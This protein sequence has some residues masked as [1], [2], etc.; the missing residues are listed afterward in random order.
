[1]VSI[2]RRRFLTISA[3]ALLAGKPA[4]AEPLR[5]WRGVALGAEV[6]IVLAHPEG[7][8]ISARAFAEIERLERIFSLYREESELSLLNRDGELAQPSFDML[9]CLGLC[10]AIHN[11][12][13]G[14]FDPTV[15]PLWRYYAEVYG[16]GGEPDPTMLMQRRGLVDLKSVRFDSAGIR[17]LKLG[18]AMTLNGIAQGFIA[19]KV[20]A[21]LRAEGLTDL[22]VNTGEIQALG[23]S[24]NDG[25]NGWPVT[26]KA[27]DDFLPEAIRLSD[28]A[29]AS[30]APLGTTIDGSGRVSHIISPRTG[31]PT[32]AIWRL[33]SISS[34][35]AAIADALSTAGCL[36]KK[37]SLRAAI[38]AFPGAKLELLA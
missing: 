6:M 9:E 32:E 22:L 3:A 7:D 2:D 24:P 29:L 13:D 26:L 10:N 20:A 23:N 35:S 21:L 4:F 27:G 17:Y 30:S 1:M 11:A 14:Q 5:Q 28:R 31:K 34:D 15:Q 38:A 8:R 18:M 37:D 19:D 16:A 25:Q 12:T 36:M 33:V